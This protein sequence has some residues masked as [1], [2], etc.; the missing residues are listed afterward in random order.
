MHKTIATI[1]GQMQ[2]YIDSKNGVLNDKDIAYLAPFAS[3]A[4]SLMKLEKYEEK[5][6]DKELEN[7]KEELTSG[8]HY[9]DMYKKTNDRDYLKMAKDEVGHAQK[10]ILGMLSRKMEKGEEQNVIS[11]KEW[12]D[13]IL[14]KIENEMA[15]IS[16][17]VKREVDQ[18]EE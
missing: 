14:K 8:E 16:E 9:W 12:H 17:E 1:K 11:A 2:R 4:M 5:E 7:I 3:T 10:F 6:L 13:N 18:Y 15:E